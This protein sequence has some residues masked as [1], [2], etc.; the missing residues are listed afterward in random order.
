MT[1]VGPLTDRRGEPSWAKPSAEANNL[2][3]V[4]RRV[5]QELLDGRVDGRWLANSLGRGSSGRRWRAPRQS[6]RQ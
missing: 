3:D 1:L 4:V 6:L 5:D 2:L